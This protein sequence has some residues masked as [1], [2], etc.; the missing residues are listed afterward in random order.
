MRI[1]IDIHSVERDGSG[2]CTYV[3][4]LVTQLLQLDKQDEY[5]LFG[6]QPDHPFYKS[7]QAPNAKLLF[8]SSSAFYR[9]FVSL[10]GLCKKEKLDLL[11]VHY[12]CP[13]RADTKL[14]VT[15]HDLTPL[16]FPQYF[17]FQE[18]IM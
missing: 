11:H 17:S 13:W 5:V 15:I 4:N 14:V 2:N 8:T 12:F 7:I 9:Y 18:R 16:R 1:G 3:R 6:T 10:P